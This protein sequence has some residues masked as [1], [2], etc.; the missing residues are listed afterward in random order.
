MNE[1]LEERLE[2]WGNW[3]VREEDN[4]LGYPSRSLDAIVLEEAGVLEKRRG[5]RAIPINPNV[6]EIESMVRELSKRD[7]ILAKALREKYVGRGTLKARA[8]NLGISYSTF[9]IYVELAKYWLAGR[10]SISERS[11]N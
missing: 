4:G 9:K 3:C 6:D 7:P 11:R 5:H 8:N 1:T 2:K 10:L